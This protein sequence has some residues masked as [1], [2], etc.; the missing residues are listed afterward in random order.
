M[1]VPEFELKSNFLSSSSSLNNLSVIANK[2]VGYI[3]L[4]PYS[5]KKS[6]AISHFKVA[7]YPILLYFSKSNLYSK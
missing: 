2:S 7:S 3:E 5:L 4:V 1:L 6:K